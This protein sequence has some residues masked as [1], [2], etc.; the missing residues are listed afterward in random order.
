MDEKEQKKKFTCTLRQ[1]QITATPKF[2]QTPRE[3]P[4]AP[5]MSSR[6]GET[7]GCL[8]FHIDSWTLHDPSNM[9]NAFR[10]GERHWKRAPELGANLRV[11]IRKIS[12]DSRARRDER[13]LRGRDRTLSTS[14]NGPAERRRSSRAGAGVTRSTRTLPGA[15]DGRF[16]GSASRERVFARTSRGRRGDVARTLHDF[17]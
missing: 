10:G 14:D 16:R 11:G 17:R 1:R 6:S 4:D 5:S 9:S 15:R 3:T 7:Q 8:T 12:R 13:R 2:T